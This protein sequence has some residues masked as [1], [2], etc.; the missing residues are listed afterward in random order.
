LR[1]QLMMADNATTVSTI[2][3]DFLASTEVLW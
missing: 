3:Q 1:Q 2:I